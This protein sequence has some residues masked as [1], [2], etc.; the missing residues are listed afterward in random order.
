MNDT[1]APIEAEA[2]RTTAAKPASKRST[3]AVKKTA[4]KKAP[5]K[6]TAKATAKRATAKKAT[7]SKATAPAKKATAAKKATPAKQPTLIN[8]KVKGESSAPAGHPGHTWHKLLKHSGTSQSAAARHMGVALMSLNRLVNGRGIPTAHMTVLFA[9][10]VN[11][12]LEPLWAEV[13]QWELKEAKEQIARE[14]KN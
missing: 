14:R 12:E 8:G 4:A 2:K 3:A 10:A 6:T 9:E 13:C 1:T 11:A 5:A 7:A